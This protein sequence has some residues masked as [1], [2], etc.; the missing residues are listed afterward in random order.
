MQN[1]EINT[2]AQAAP[3]ES[4][5]R[6]DARNHINL[7]LA[8]FPA[9]QFM[10]IRCFGETN[11]GLP[12]VQKW[13]LNTDEH[14]EAG[15]SD[16]LNAAEHLSSL[17]YGIFQS[18]NPR[19]QSPGTKDSVH[20]VVSLFI[21]ADLYK[22][23]KSYQELE[24]FIDSDGCPVK[25]S[26][27]LSSG[28]GYQLIW[29]HQAAGDFV[30][31]EQLQTR[32][33]VC[34]KDF[35]SDPAVTSDRSRVL[36]LCPFPNWKTGQPRATAIVRVTDREP[37][38]I[39]ELLSAFAGV[40][41]PAAEI[42]ASSGTT[43]HM[44]EEIPEGGTFETSG[45][46]ATVFAQ[47]IKWHK[48]GYK[49][50]EIQAAMEV[51]NEGRCKPPL[52]ARELNAVLDSVCRYEGGSEIS[53]QAADEDAIKRRCT[54]VGNAEVFAKQYGEDARYCREKKAWL[55]W[56]GKRW[57][58]DGED[59]THGEDCKTI[60]QMAMEYA[61]KIFDEAKTAGTH[62]QKVGRHA[63]Y[64]NSAKGIQ[65]MLSLAQDVQ[66][67]SLSMS[68]MDARQDVLNVLNGTI[69]LRTGKLMP[70]RRGD[71]CSKLAPVVFDPDAKAPRF[72]QCLREVFAGEHCDDL[73]NYVHRVV[74]YTLTGST[75]EHCFFILYG[76]GR[77]GKGTLVRALLG[78]L[79][80]YGATTSTSV[81]LMKK[82][83]GGAATP[84]LAALKGI[85]FAEASE[86]DAKQRL[87]EALV[88]RITGGD[89]VECRFLNE[90]PF[91][92]TPEFKLWLSTN[93]KPQVAGTDLGMW[94]RIKLI[95]F[96]NKFEGSN[97][98]ASLDDKLK[99]E[100]PGILA[101]AVR[102]A[103]EFYRQGLG[104]CAAVE[105]ATQEYRA[106]SDA[107]AKFILECC[108]MDAKASVQSGWFHTEFTRW[109]AEEGEES[110]SVKDF[111]AAMLK[112][113][114]TYKRGKTGSLWAGIKAKLSEVGTNRNSGQTDENLWS[115]PQVP[116]CPPL[117][118]TRIR[119]A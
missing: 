86:T 115:N 101:W 98:D 111:K 112:K 74:G 37:M 66:G 76:D 107:L 110:L 46:N 31:W 62:M 25:P 104:T 85:R 99:A 6:I 106:E 96:V 3:V 15:I 103:V 51:F 11:K 27:V 75:A 20:Q 8:H 77:N 60:R 65:N 9:N 95:P 58:K 73:V 55:T 40:A 113:G 47:A 89:A 28:G 70:H 117:V 78:M 88:K 87:A 118:T 64:T 94:S 26:V 109:C 63:I 16:A 18:M 69:D 38:E 43:R 35:G 36:R 57:I 12:P 61:A 116:V 39:E 93:H 100:L 97:K 52:D 19:V 48:Q 23:D 5:Q 71:F 34:F 82:D 17:G 33:E 4:Q 90:N 44:P 42:T 84:E 54:D 68:K 105:A 29:F 32:L 92:Y 119:S 14:R 10:E 24:A 91:V 53:S 79:G 22:V 45:R 2:L 108:E 56:S 81:L 50:P 114:F 30:K 41:L 59:L 67:M 83:N 13:I 102:G 72:E 80:D 49:R 1:N 7:M 21:D